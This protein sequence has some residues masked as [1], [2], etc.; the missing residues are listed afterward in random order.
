M[1]VLLKEQITVEQLSSLPLEKVLYQWCLW[2]GE[3]S[4]FWRHFYPESKESFDIVVRNILD[5]DPSYL[6]I[7]E[8]N[9]I[10]PDHKRYLTNEISHHMPIYQLHSYIDQLDITQQEAARNQ[11]KLLKEKRVVIALMKI[12]LC[13]EVEKIK[14]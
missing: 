11:L 13:K 5:N 6:S 4:L 9:K 3:E 10:L 8:V 1:T 7:D 12:G 2:L 14:G